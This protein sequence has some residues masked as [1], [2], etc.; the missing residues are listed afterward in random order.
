MKL[1]LGIHGM[2]NGLVTISG[3]K[4]PMCTNLLSY[5]STLKNNEKIEKTKS[6]SRHKAWNR[7]SKIR[8]Q[9]T[10]SH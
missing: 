5:T 6:A 2:M 7:G 10:P 8:K 9:K 1:Q 3:K 4:G